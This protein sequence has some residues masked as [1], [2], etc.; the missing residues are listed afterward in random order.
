M[1]EVGLRG[2]PARR[3]PA[4]AVG[5]AAL[6]VAGFAAAAVTVRTDLGDGVRF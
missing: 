5:V 1:V 2:E 3:R 6:A 4:A